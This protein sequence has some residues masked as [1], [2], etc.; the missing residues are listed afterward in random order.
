MALHGGVVPFGATCF[1][2]SDDM[3]PAIRPAAL[4]AARVIH[5]WA[6]DS[7][8]FGEDGPTDQPVEGAPELVFVSTGSQVSL[9][10]GARRCPADRAGAETAQGRKGWW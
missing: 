8:A 1:T 10:L 5:V 6:H 4:S 3:R 2:F 7:I 9:A